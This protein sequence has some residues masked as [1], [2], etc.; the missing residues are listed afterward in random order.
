MKSWEPN[1]LVQ[2]DEDVAY[3][4]TDKEGLQLARGLT[5]ELRLIMWR[6]RV[7]HLREH[8]WNCRCTLTPISRI[9]TDPK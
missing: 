5:L 6:A 1:K 4:P 8:T 9:D 2:D 3:E 7:G